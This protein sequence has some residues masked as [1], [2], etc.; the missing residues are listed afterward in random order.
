MDNFNDDFNKAVELQSNLSGNLLERKQ[1]ILKG[2]STGRVDYRLKGGV[3]SLKNDLKQLQ[4][5]AYL[6]KNDN[7]KYKGIA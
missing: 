6:Y 4:K 1:L 2:N 7:I 5:I 3:E